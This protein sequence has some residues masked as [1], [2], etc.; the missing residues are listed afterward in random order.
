MSLIRN[1]IITINKSLIDLNGWPIFLFPVHKAIR[2]ILG[3]L[4][5]SIL[6]ILYASIN[7]LFLCASSTFDMSPNIILI[8]LL[9][10]SSSYAYF[11]GIINVLLIALLK[12]TSHLLMP[13]LFPLQFFPRCDS[14]LNGIQA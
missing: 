14:K 11:M 3:H 4:V 6:K 12:R 10:I 1:L 5:Y 13:T 8:S 2:N 9:G 7:C